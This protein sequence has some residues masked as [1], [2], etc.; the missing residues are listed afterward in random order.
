MLLFQKSSN[1]FFN[2]NLSKVLEINYNVSGIKNTFEMF[3]L[4]FS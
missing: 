4:M 1:F 2:R 3:L